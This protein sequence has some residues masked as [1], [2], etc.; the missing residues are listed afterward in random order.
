MLVCYTI[1]F[2]VWN[3]H[4]C[5]ISIFFFL[6]N[7]DFF[8]LEQQC[9][10]TTLLEPAL[11][12]RLYNRVLENWDFFVLEQQCA[13]FRTPSTCLQFQLFC[14]KPHPKSSYCFYYFI[15]FIL[16]V[17]FVGKFGPRI[18]FWLHNC[19]QTL[20]HWTRNLFIIAVICFL[21]VGKRVEKDN[22]EQLFQQII[23][24]YYMLGGTTTFYY[25]L[26]CFSSLFLSYFFSFL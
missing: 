23:S 2:F 20:L 18:D 26:I 16:L 11:F 3:L 5:S 25:Y 7:W 17:I 4:N 24:L 12:Y 19:S 1:I 21:Q 13:F 6:Q 14:L 9:V 15:F 10:L 22:C 8:V